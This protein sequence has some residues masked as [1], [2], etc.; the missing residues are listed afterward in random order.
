VEAHRR[1]RT[2]EVVGTSECGQY[3]QILRRNGQTV[4]ANRIDI[5]ENRNQR[6][7]IRSPDPSQSRAE[8]VRDTDKVM[9]ELYEKYGTTETF[10][11]EG[12]GVSPVMLAR[13]V[14]RGVLE[15]VGKTLARTPKSAGYYHSNVYRF[16]G[17]ITARGL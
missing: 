4:Y 6:I 16:T 9:Q 17:R 8:R 3:Y 12:S 13:Y 11:H 15:V 1:G 5:D 2:W 14:R 7:V 10:V